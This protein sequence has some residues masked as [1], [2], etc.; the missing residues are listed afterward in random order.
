MACSG[1]EERAWFTS[2]QRRAMV[3]EFHMSPSAPWLSR[4][5]RLVARLTR[6][7]PT[8]LSAPPRRSILEQWM[9]QQETD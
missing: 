1:C 2:A 7:Q 6:P 8:A 3:R 4:F 5:W 9:Q